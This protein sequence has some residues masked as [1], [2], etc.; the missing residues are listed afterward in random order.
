[1][2]AQCSDDSA[3]DSL[4]CQVQQPLSSPSSTQQAPAV[5]D[6]SGPDQR[7][8]RP[9]LSSEATAVGSLPAGSE[10]NEGPSG[11]ERAQPRPVQ[12]PPEPPSEFQRFVDAT[13]GQSLRVYGAGLFTDRQVSFGPVDR[14]PAPADLILS[15]GD[16]LQIRIWGQ[17]NFSANLRIGREGQIYL[18]KVGAVHVAGLTVA[19]AEAHLRQAMER[20]YRNFELSV[21]LG[22]IHSI[23]VY[24]AGWSRQPGEYTVSALS[25]LV[26]AVFLS[27]GPSNAGSMRHVVL[28]RDGRV[29][30][31]F[32]LYDLLVK[33]D[34]T[35]DVKLQPG[36]VLYIP[37]VGPQVALLGSVRQPAIYELRGEESLAGLLDAAGG[38]TPMAAGARISVDRIAD[39]AVRR[40]FEIDGDAEGLSAKLAD[41]DIV[42][43]DPIASNYRDTV[44]LR[45][46]VANPGH[47]RWRPGMHLSDLIPDRDSLVARG[48]WWRRTQLGLPAPEFAEAPAAES[49]TAPA[50]EFAAKPDRPDSPPI[51]PGKSEQGGNSALAAGQNT[52]K[53]PV[54]SSP[55]GETDWNYAVIE[56]L[57]PATMTTS[58]I[59]FGLGKL[60]FDRDASQDLALEPGDVIT[61]FSQEDI[62]P[63]IDRKTKYVQLEGEIVNAGVYSVSPEETL[64]SLVE[65]AGGL[66]SKAY[67]FGAEF[68]RK[69]T[70][71]IEQQRMNEI[72]DRLEHL[73][74]RNAV[75]SPAV[76][77]Q[78]GQEGQR[79]GLALPN[80]SFLT[81]LRQARATGRIVLN[82]PPGSNSAADLPEMALEDGDRLVVPSRPSTVQVVGAVFNQNAFLYAKDARVGRFLSLAGGPTREADRHQIFVLRADGSVVHRQS[83][84]SIFDSATLDEVHLYPG[85]TVVVPEKTVRPSA[86]RELADWT[87][88]MSQLTLSA[89]ALNAVK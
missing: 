67:L 16:E 31:D 49:A 8:P 79:T 19:A 34:K 5:F 3:P 82:L 54:L 74:E 48:Y 57:D 81:R 42:R 25:T 65:R 10:Y 35:G 46:S 80:Q 30:T 13:T 86:L 75:Q 15:A 68:T 18:P 23:Q 20:I 52:E 76:A 71:A 70:Q 26:D 83:G 28:K 51:A 27:G 88:I 7:Q 24:L 37:P 45:G 33:G 41:G 59:P 50:P 89:A 84:N 39:R 56:R 85:D 72:S 78:N 63:P 17:V 64:R 61:V 4:A 6:I 55:G 62:H 40:A 29:L 38:R 2:H 53:P 58:L 60:V 9:D 69:S 66:T 87:Q 12:L 1:M 21:D 32:D 11:R 36:D 43:V 77:G 14:A 44:T 47:F 73:M 22:E